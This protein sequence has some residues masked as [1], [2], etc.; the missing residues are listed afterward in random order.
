MSAVTSHAKKGVQSASSSTTFRAIIDS[1]TAEG[2]RM[3][4]DDAIAV[5]V[6]VCT[7]L[8]ERHARGEVHFVHAS[9]IARCPDG[10]YRLNPTLAVPPKDPKDKAALAPE[11]L[12]SNAPGN[13]RASVFAVGAMLYEAVCGSPVGP[14]M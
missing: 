2:G 6:P 10:L 3:S 5:I 9:A 12:K 4:L 13:A 11:V 8:K 1:R 7:D 14:G